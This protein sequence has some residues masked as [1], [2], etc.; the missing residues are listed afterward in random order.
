[1]YR[2][3]LLACDFV[4]DDLSDR[5][6]DYPT[7]FAQALAAAEVPVDWQVYRAYAGELPHDVEECDGYMTT[8]SRNGANDSEPWISAL[9]KFV[10][11]L[12]ESKRPLV[13]ICFGHQ[14][15][16]HALGGE[17]QQS[18]RGW[19]IGVHNYSLREKPAWMSL[20]GATFTVPVCHQDQI[21]QLPVGA[22]VLAGNA[23][24]GNFMVQFNETTLGIQGHPEFQ[25]AYIEALLATRSDIIPEPTFSAAQNSLSAKHDNSDIMRTLGRFLGVL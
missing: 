17:V 12:V 7:M 2:L 24:C 16:A 11:R 8:G 21:E 15:I 14:I 13:G 9:I 23:H 19:G 10:Q 3:G 20:N 25:P 22:T 18:K 1:M 6:D 4:P 5:F